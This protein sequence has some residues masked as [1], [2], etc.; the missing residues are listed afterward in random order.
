M[1]RMQL[2]LSGLGQIPPTIPVWSLIMEDLAF[3][4]V[5]SVMRVLGVEADQVQEWN[6]TGRAPKWACLALFW[7]TRWGRSEVHQQA[8]HDAIVA[9]QCL[10]AVERERDRL[11]EAVE[12][13]RV[14]LA[15]LRLVEAPAGY[16]G[17]A[18]GLVE[19]SGFDGP[20]PGPEG[21]F[22][23]PREAETWAEPSP[24]GVRLGASAIKGS[25]ASPAQRGGA[26]PGLVSVP[27]S[28]TR[29]MESM[30]P[31]RARYWEAPAQEVVFRVTQRHEA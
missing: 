29:P 25:E 20:A 30:P 1:P 21:V 9:V 10:R 17:E 3:P 31:A 11:A 12:V 5:G 24:A 27:T 23:P 6:R 8:T 19:V 16:R 15:G 13:M 4:D 26:I 18:P 14:G 22:A 2:Q 28:G 7:L